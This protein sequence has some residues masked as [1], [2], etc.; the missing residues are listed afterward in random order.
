MRPV[1]LTAAPPVETSAPRARAESP[2][3]ADGSPPVAVAATPT[4]P[5]P[6]R[7][8]RVSRRRT[9]EEE[10]SDVPP[11]EIGSTSLGDYAS[12]LGPSRIAPQKSVRARFLMAG[13]PVAGVT[14]E[15]RKSDAEGRIALTLPRNY[16]GFLVVSQ[17]D[18]VQLNI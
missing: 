16:R 7:D 10:P 17:P 11:I 9:P 6:R 14:I 15:G 18:G 5:V 13:R 2:T 4:T 8:A 3:S 12:S 1:A